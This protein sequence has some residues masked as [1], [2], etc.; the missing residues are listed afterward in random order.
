[1][2]RHGSDLRPIRPSIVAPQVSTILEQE[3]TQ[4]P[5]RQRS[6]SFNG[7]ESGFSSQLSIIRPNGSQANRSNDRVTQTSSDATARKFPLVRSHSFSTVDDRSVRQSLGRLASKAPSVRSGFSRGMSD[8]SFSQTLPPIPALPM[9]IP[10]STVDDFLVPA[11]TRAISAA[12]EK[13]SSPRHSKQKHDSSDVQLPSR[14]P[15]SVLSRQQQVPEPLFQHP[16]SSEVLVPRPKAI[17]NSSPRTSMGQMA[18]NIYENI[19]KHPNDPSLIRFA[20]GTDEIIAA[21]PSML[22]A[23]ITSPNFLDYELLSDFFLTYRAFMTSSDLV[24]FLIARLSWAV[25]RPDDFGRIVRVRTFVALRHW[26]LNYYSDDFVPD[27]ALRVQF[28]DLVN[29]LFHDLQTRQD[30]GG[31]DIKIIGELKKCWRR[32]CGLYWRTARLVQAPEDD[33]FPGGRPESI[34]LMTDP[35]SPLP[36][37]PEQ[38]QTIAEKRVQVAR[39]NGKNEPN[40][41]NLKTITPANDMTQRADD[42]Q[43][44]PMSVQSLHV[45]SCSFPIKLP[46]ISL[47][48]KDSHSKSQTKLGPRVAVTSRSPTPT[49]T[50][51]PTMPHK[52]PLSF[53]E[54]LKDPKRRSFVPE[55]RVVDFAEE[56]EVVE[57]GSLIHGGMYEPVSPYFEFRSI[58]ARSS[59]YVHSAQGDSPRSNSGDGGHKNFFGSLRKAFGSQNTSAPATVTYHSPEQFYSQQGKGNLSATDAE[60]LNAASKVQVR[61]DLLS[62]FA[63]EKFEDA[64]EDVHEETDEKEEARSRASKTFSEHLTT[65]DIRRDQP[66]KSHR[67]V[68][69]GSRSIVIV[70]DTNS[71]LPM[72]SGALSPGPF[73][74]YPKELPVPSQNPTLSVPSANKSKQP[75]TSAFSH[76]KQMTGGAYVPSGFKVGERG[77]S[78]GVVPHRKPSASIKSRGSA[79][80]SVRKYVSYHSGVSQRTP[81]RRPVSKSSDT[82]PNTSYYHVPSQKLRRKPGGNLKDSDSVNDSGRKLPRRYS[83][84]SLST[85]SRAGYAESAIDSGNR[86]ISPIADSDDEISYRTSAPVKRR[87]KSISLIATH[88]SQPNLRA[89]FE[90][91]VAKLKALPD[92]EDDG[93]V[94]ATLLKLEGKYEKKSPSSTA[95]QS[96]IALLFSGEDTDL[97]PPEEEEIEEEEE[98]RRRHHEHAEDVHPEHTLEEEAGEPLPESRPV[99]IPGDDE[100]EEFH[101]VAEDRASMALLS[102]RG[103]K[104]KKSEA[105]STASYSS[106]PLLQR[107]RETGQSRDQSTL[108]TEAPSVEALL[109]HAESINNST[110]D[111]HATPKKSSQIAKRK[112]PLTSFLLDDTQE[113]SDDDILGVPSTAVDDDEDDGDKK[114]F[115]DDEED[116]PVAPRRQSNKPQNLR[117]PAIQPVP[118]DAII[119]PLMQM[120]PIQPTSFSQGLPTPAGSP[121]MYSPPGRHPHASQAD[122]PVKQRSAPTSMAAN[123]LPMTPRQSGSVHASHLPFS[124]AYP[125][126]TVAQQLTLIEKDALDSLDWREL[127]D[128]S[129]NQSPKNLGDWVSYLRSQEAWG[130]AIVI[131]RFNLT[132]KWCLSEI[133]LTDTAPERARA[134]VHFIHIAAGCRRIRNF[135]TMYQITVALLSADLLR[136]KRTWALVP[137]AE[138]ATLADL[139]QLVQPLRNF[140][141]LRVEMETSPANKGCIPFIGIYTRDLVYNAQ[142]PPVV[143]TPPVNDI[144]PLVNFERHR[145][146]AGTVKTLLRLLEMSG[147]YSFRRDAEVLARCLWIASMNENDIRERC[148]KVD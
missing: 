142:K 4:A 130:I 15:S 51:L 61:I 84:A 13:A 135:A 8:D 91:E 1:V 23:H 132:V 97:S 104:P 85:V 79:L 60:Q 21:T 126:D 29:S 7:Q 72:M 131:A 9:P 48:S 30:G 114:S 73:D 137:S 121:E 58:L 107:Q 99:H 103:H 40:T 144:E 109:R 47:S 87:G 32:T 147:K 20:A 39:M 43:L 138:M 110:S 65:L 62:S 77:A 3:Y 56:P 86:P 46:M 90:A 26:I 67:S 105:E 22:I 17:R 59:A 128:L 119:A 111:L 57:P 143:T 76:V 35:E 31:G 122:M 37:K 71:D 146:A 6:N 41:S 95:P 75:L 148:E 24:A 55:T 94:E 52:R 28:C 88:S 89:S 2:S 36:P 98:R 100:H 96:P 141:N 33:I 108:P 64:L 106:I 92:D 124:L 42:G 5:R 134:I 14:L 18:L 66:R 27:L 82:Q 118:L 117:S 83:L 127:I 145:T 80:S 74:D 12:F 69:R 25:D 133:V 34:S 11:T 53:F 81:P 140:H 44:S 112:E 49:S 63:A 101:E 19:L 120:R 115:F 70:D 116:S 68:S 16:D 136:L 45:L 125:A 113:L 123:K 139:E 78:K 129:W 54:N 50:A 38:T 93:G 10:T 102:Q